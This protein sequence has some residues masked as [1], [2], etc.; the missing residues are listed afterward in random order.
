MRVEELDNFLSKLE[1]KYLSNFSEHPYFEEF[2]IG[3][4]LPFKYENVIHYCKMTEEERESTKKMI[5]LKSEDY[6]M[7]EG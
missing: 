7:K 4:L 2:L 5:E 1:K 3:K 6:K